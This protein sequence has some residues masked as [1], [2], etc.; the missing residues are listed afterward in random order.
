MRRTKLDTEQTRLA[1]LDAAETLFWEQ[2]AA[3]TSVLDI[4]RTAGLTRGA[5]YHH[6]KDKAAI[7]EALIARSLDTDLPG[8]AEGTDLDALVALR[9]CCI[10]VFE[11]FVQD[12]LRQRMFGN[13]G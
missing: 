11:R 9:A 8:D 6:F 7:F 2:G 5:F 10:V 4:A 13:P 12:R 1:L 3:R